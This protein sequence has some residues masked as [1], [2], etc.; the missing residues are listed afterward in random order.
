MGPFEKY[1]SR[2]NHIKIYKY[3]P[4]FE[5]NLANF[6]KQSIQTC[7]IFKLFVID[8]RKL[9]HKHLLITFT[10]YIQQNGFNLKF[11]VFKELLWVAYE[12]LFSQMSVGF[13]SYSADGLSSCITHPFPS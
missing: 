9:S 5:L 7:C 1:L 3:L 8:K 13:E 12:M 4:R 6:L 10:L 2:I 11:T